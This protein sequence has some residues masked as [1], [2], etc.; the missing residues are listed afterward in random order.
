LSA[1]AAL[2]LGVQVS[3]SMESP[4]HLQHEQMDAWVE[5]TLDPPERKRI[6]THASQC[7]VCAARLRLY[8]EGTSAM[9]APVRHARPSKPSAASQ[10]PTARPAQVSGIRAIFASPP[11]LLMLLAGIGAV[12]LVPYLAFR[13]IPET[14]EPN[15][16]TPPPDVP[17]DLSALDNLPP[18]VANG[19]RDVVLNEA[20]EL[21]DILAGVPAP[22]GF[23]LIYPVTETVEATQPMLTWQPVGPPPYKVVVTDARRQVVAQTSGVPNPNWM[24]PVPLE[25]GSTYTWQMTAGDGTSEQA[26]F[27]VLDQATL[28]LW[29]GVRSQLAN[30]DLALGAVAQ[31]LGLLTVAER[32]FQE[33]VQ[34]NP[35]SSHAGRLLDNV[36]AL[37]DSS[38]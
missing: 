32:E 23:G 8:Q 6:E 36:L 37:R 29:Q 28:T 38:Q 20:P 35:N 1:V 12:V 26:S 34:A 16:F 30:S 31:S 3:S 13:T 25:R 27:R 2:L 9:D 4:E 33:L 18:A 19:A 14:G 5:N 15:S 17:L 11:L 7:R 22:S 24:I 10:I 21:P